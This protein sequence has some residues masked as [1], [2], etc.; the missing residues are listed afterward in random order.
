[1]LA[2]KFSLLCFSFHFIWQRLFFLCFWYIAAKYK[3]VLINLCVQR[4]TVQADKT[5]DLLIC[6]MMEQD[7][8]C[9]WANS[10]YSSGRPSNSFSWG[11]PQHQFSGG[12]GHLA[13]TSSTTVGCLWP[14]YEPLAHSTVSAGCIGRARDNSSPQ[15]QIHNISSGRPSLEIFL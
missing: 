8:P 12:H 4:G 10:Y 13:S 3:E 1:M 9:T 2:K 11:Y 7:L 14:W 6:G 15:L 5:K